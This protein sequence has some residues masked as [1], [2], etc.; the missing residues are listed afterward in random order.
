MKNVIVRDHL[1]RVTDANYRRWLR[2][3]A[4][5]HEAPVTFLGPSLGPVVMGTE[6]SSTVASEALRDEFRERTGH[7]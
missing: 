1:Y 7:N 6:L 3:V 4:T 2:A 5:G